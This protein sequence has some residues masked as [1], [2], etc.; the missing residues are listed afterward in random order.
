VT[1]LTV[2]GGLSL[3]IDLTLDRFS[4]LILRHR[5][6]GSLPFGITVLKAPDFESA[7]S[8][9]RDRLECQHAVG[10]ATIG[11]DVAVFRDFPEAARQGLGVHSMSGVPFS[12]FDH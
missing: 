8:K 2:A 7:L 6:S 11:D 10:A 3:M 12:K 1:Q 5:Q 4:P 9:H